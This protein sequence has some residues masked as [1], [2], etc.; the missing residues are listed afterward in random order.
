MR[1][2]F[3]LFEHIPILGGGHAEMI[4]EGFAETVQRF[5]FQQVRDILALHPH[6]EQADRLVEAFFVVI[7][8]QGFAHHLGEK[9]GDI[10]IA[11]SHLIADI[12]E[13]FDGADIGV[14][15]VDDGID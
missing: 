3:L 15:I 12:M 7:R 10:G 1:L 2:G 4:A 11:V 9:A 6:L 5:V 13:V 8:L 14:D